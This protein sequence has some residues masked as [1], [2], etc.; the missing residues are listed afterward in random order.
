MSSNRKGLEKRPK[1]RGAERPSRCRSSHPGR[2][3][4]K[5][6]HS[7]PGRRTPPQPVRQAWW[8]A[9]GS[10][11]EGVAQAQFVGE[12]AQCHARHHTSTAHVERFRPEE[13]ARWAGSNPAPNAARAAVFRK[14]LRSCIIHRFAKRVSKSS[15]PSGIR[16]Q[17]TAFSPRQP[18]RPGRRRLRRATKKKARGAC[19]SDKRIYWCREA[20]CATTAANTVFSRRADRRVRRTPLRCTCRSRSRPP[21]L[22]GSPKPLRQFRH[23]RC[24]TC[25]L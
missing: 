18:H 13:A 22:Q 15:K 12:E 1:S 25:C 23:R 10:H 21:H 3:A 14:V 24:T 20:T 2:E 9:I 19:L 4:W 17:S 11:G 6:R 16:I 7:P 8:C 5:P